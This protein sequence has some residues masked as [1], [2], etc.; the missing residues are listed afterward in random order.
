M[1]GVLLCIALCFA[2][3]GVLLGEL[4]EAGVLA[5]SLVNELESERFVSSGVLRRV[6]GIRPE[7]GDIRD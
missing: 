6:P 7:F 5:D 4:C 3:D 2:L 1:D